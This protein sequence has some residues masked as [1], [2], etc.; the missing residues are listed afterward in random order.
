VSGYLQS[1]RLFSPHRP[2]GIIG[3]GN[4][5]VPGATKERKNSWFCRRLNSGCPPLTCPYNDYTIPVVVLLCRL[6]LIGKWWSQLLATDPQVPGS[7]PGTA[8][9]SEAVGLE[10]C[11]FTLVTME[12]LGWKSSASTEIIGRRHTLVW[13]L[14]IPPAV[15]V[16]TNFAHTWRPLVQYSSLPD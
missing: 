6:V 10:R 8:I 3:I 2:H 11:P 9:S 16:G 13:P 14:D 1:R 4:C 7:I 15:K 12:L 5:V